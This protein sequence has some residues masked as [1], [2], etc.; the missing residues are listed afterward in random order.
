MFFDTLAELRD[1]E[2][3]WGYPGEAIR[4]G[5]IIWLLSLLPLFIS[6][7]VWDVLNPET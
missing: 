5:P 7:Q 3:L 1:Q 2:P 4:T 6:L